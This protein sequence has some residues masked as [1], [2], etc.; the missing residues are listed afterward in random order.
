[1][2]VEFAL[3]LICFAAD[4]PSTM[5]NDFVLNRWPFNNRACPL[6]TARFRGSLSLGQSGT[7]CVG[8]LDRSIRGDPWPGPLAVH[9]DKCCDVTKVDDNGGPVANLSCQLPRE[10]PIVS[11]LIHVGRPSC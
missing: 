6:C 9:V 8:T 2:H 4:K 5:L 10:R 11:Y 7:D 3:S 1:M